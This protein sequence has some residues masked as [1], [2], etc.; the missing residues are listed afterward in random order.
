MNASL[1]TEAQ[2][3]CIRKTYGAAFLRVSCNMRGLIS[4]RE[5]VVVV[6]RRTKEGLRALTS[7]S[8]AL[9]VVA[10]RS[11]SLLLQGVR[12]A[13]WPRARLLLLLLLHAHKREGL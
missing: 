5:V 1:F 10:Q 12:L 11:R 2:R 9:R 4:K 8:F 3:S 6:V 7:S 13:W